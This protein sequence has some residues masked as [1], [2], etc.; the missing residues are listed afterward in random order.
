[1]GLIPLDLDS[2]PGMDVNKA[3][4][5]NTASLLQEPTSRDAGSIACSATQLCAAPWAW[6]ELQIR[7][8][9]GDTAPVTACIF[10][11]LGTQLSLVRYQ[12]LPEQHLSGFGTSWR[13]QWVNVYRSLL[14]L[15]FCWQYCPRS[16]SA[17][18]G[19]TLYARLIL[20][21]SGWA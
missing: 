6:R 5:L 1:M 4:D 20:I 9:K 15:E 18:R 17:K 11:L 3:L 13:N 16:Y 8:N 19:L 12:P 21:V 7:L 2:K 14:S 10:G